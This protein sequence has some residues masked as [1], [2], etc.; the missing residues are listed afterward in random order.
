MTPFIVIAVAAVAVS[1][2]VRKWAKGLDPAPETHSDQHDLIL[3]ARA[4]ETESMSEEEEEQVTGDAEGHVYG[5]PALA[6]G[7]WSL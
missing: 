7:E 2:A 4:G 6:H 5:T 3:S 1:V